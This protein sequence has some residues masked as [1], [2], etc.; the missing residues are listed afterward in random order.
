VIEVRASQPDYQPDLDVWLST[1]KERQPDMFFVCNPN[2]PTGWHFSDSD[3][4]HLARAMR[5]NLV[6]IDEAYKGFTDRGPFGKVPLNNVIVLRSMTKDFALAGLRLGY[7]LA[8]PSLIAAMQRQQPPWSVNAF[9]QAAGLAALEDLDHLHRTIHDT[10]KWAHQ[11]KSDLS[12]RDARISPSPMHYFMVE[13]G[14]GRAVRKQ[15]LAHG[16]LVR[17]AASFDLPRWIRI[18]VRRPEENQR[19]LELWHL[20]G[21]AQS[22]DEIDAHA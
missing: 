13:V 2:N 20:T 14:D 9:A 7:A 12:R 10:L 16:C 17:D 18:G 19:L 21:F 3:L 5:P 4:A 1:I 11:L 22:R 6:V 15:L 8:K